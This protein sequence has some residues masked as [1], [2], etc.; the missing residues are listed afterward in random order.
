[1]Y[2]DDARGAVARKNALLNGRRF[3]GRIRELGRDPITDVARV[4]R[5]RDVRV[6]LV[7]DRVERHRNDLGVKRNRRFGDR[8]RAVRGASRDDDDGGEECDSLHAT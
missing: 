8:R 4:G 1:L 5:L 3:A 2:F 7:V 6:L